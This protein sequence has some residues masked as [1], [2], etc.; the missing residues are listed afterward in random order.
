MS[1]ED[2][3]NAITVIRDAQRR[4]LTKSYSLCGAR[5]IKRS[6]S[7]VAEVFAEEVPVDGIVSLASVLDEVTAAGAAAVIRGTPGKFYPRN[8]ARAFRLLRPQEGQALAQTGARISQEQ[9][10]KHKLE[11]DGVHRYAV[12]WLPTFEDH[13][14]SWAIFDVDRVPVPD[15]MAGDWVDDPGASVEHVLGALPAPF[16]SATCWWSLSSSA[17]MPSPNGREVARDFKLKLAFWLDRGLTGAEMKRWMAAE[18]APVDPAVFRAVQPIYVA[19]PGFGPGLH[20]PVPRRSG[21]WR[22]EVDAVTVPAVLPAPHDKTRLRLQ[23]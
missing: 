11:P 18:Q 16:R 21:I 13:P 1:A 3:A 4:P 15:H 6:Y 17:A 19:R 12:T 9:I 23:H 8:G 2:A 5:I 22:G 14:R 7:N 10:R 20:D